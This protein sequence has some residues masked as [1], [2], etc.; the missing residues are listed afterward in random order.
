MTAPIMR[1]YRVNHAISSGGRILS[2]GKCE[3]HLDD[4]FL[5]IKGDRSS[6]IGY[7]QLE[8]FRPI[9]GGVEIQMF[10]EGSVRF[11][12]MDGALVRP[13]FVHLSHLRGLRWAY[14]LRYAEGT[15]IDTLEC[16]VRL[17]DLPEQE[18]LIHLYP[19]GLVGMP[20]GGE[21]FQLLMA[22]LQPIVRTPD[23]RLVCSTDE[24]TATLYGC[25]PTD[26]G[27]FQRSIEGERQK[28]EEET[29]NLL[30]E[31]FPALEFS[32]VVPLTTL[33]A[34][35]RAASKS[36]IDQAAPWLWERIQELVQTKAAYPEAFAQ[37]KARAGESLWFGVRRLSEPEVSSE[38][39][40]QSDKDL[41]SQMPGSPDTGTADE[42]VP[43][44][45]FLF[46]FLAGLK[47]GDRRFLAVE[48]DSGRK[49][50]AT[51]LYRCLEKVSDAAAYGATAS[52]IS[53]AMVA[54][55]FY[56]EPVYV[57]QR[58]IDSGRF[59]DYKLAVRK[60]KYLRD[61]R[62]LLVGR[63]IH[64]SPETWVSSLGTLL[65]SAGGS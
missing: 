21:P 41:S 60:L 64:T 30:V 10:P 23:Y 11:D 9:P 2:E 55:N 8:S 13:L 39:I 15:P 24:L 35:G 32:Q 4:A 59:A 52:A 28:M 49:G 50:Y 44:R 12:G 57:P 56:R 48:V 42:N 63:V 31:L 5:A 53:R 20:F 27:R 51:Y 19:D 65:S 14:L 18:A 40:S 1:D 6:R 25:E 54:L 33:L 17:P 43:P 46:W 62:A 38:K 7:E 61:A 26:L 16:K 22:D 36:Q 37:L 45:N 29:S 58:D 34:R 47:A 3:L